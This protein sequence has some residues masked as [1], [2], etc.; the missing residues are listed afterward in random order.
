MPT[1][2]RRILLIKP[3]S[4]GD[5]VHALP[6]AVAL[7]RRFPSASLTWLVKKQWAGV[8]E[9]SPALHRIL[10]VNLSLGGWPA[11]IRAVRAGQFDLVVDL[12]GLFRSAVLGW[13]SGAPVRVGFANAREGSPWFYTQKVAIVDPE[14]HAVDRYLLIP[15]S[16]GGAPPLIGALDF[17]LAVDSG[18]DKKVSEMLLSAG[19]IAGSPLVA[20]NAGA[21]WPTKHWP[22]RAFAEV[23][24]QLQDEGMQ[25]VVIGSVAESHPA[26]TVVGHMR[27][28]AINLVGKT[29]IK[30]LIAL[31]RRVRLLITNDSGPMHLAAALGTPVIALFGPT[32]PG[33]TGP[34][35]LG[36]RVLRSGIPCSP[37][38]SRRCVNPK[39]LECLTSI[40]PGQVFQQALQV[41]RESGDASV[42]ALKAR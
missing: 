5:I 3:S 13:L 34:Y 22:S 36:H 26:G 30:E 12:Q 14:M 41:L 39:T 2:F 21:R 9:G 28:S 23:A 8:L 35:G 4:L 33:R 38:F 27:T 24:D 15:R 6:T 11:A 40:S 16:L 18:A 32:D 7:K 42:E 20:I 25:V 17:P 37:C 19:A 10:A 31:L 29:T 1:D